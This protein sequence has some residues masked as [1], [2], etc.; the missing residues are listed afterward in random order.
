MTDKT[1]DRRSRR[2]KALAAAVLSLALLGSQALTGSAAE[3]SGSGATL[4][5][6]AAPAPSSGV[7]GTIHGD[8]TWYCNDDPR[9]LISR[10]P[11]GHVPGEFFAA[12]NPEAIDLPM[13]TKVVVSH[14]SKSVAVTIVD[15]CGR[16]CTVVIDLSLVA[17]QQL[18][19]PGRGRITVDVEWGDG[20]IVLP[21]TDTPDQ[22]G[23][24]SPPHPDDDRMRDEVRGDELYGC[25]DVARTMGQARRPLLAAP[26]TDHRRRGPGAHRVSSDG[27][28]SPE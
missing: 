14:G 7:S 19:D 25:Q 13:G 20:I 26:R 27:G 1:K 18:A 16:G 24:D 17:F 11:R 28:Q 5:A 9:W 10:C 15:T 2:P 12:I 21:A 6:Y 22:S 4:T 23:E 3:S 8:A